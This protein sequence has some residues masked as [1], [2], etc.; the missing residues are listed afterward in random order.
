MHDCSLQCYR[1]VPYHKG[2][3]ARKWQLARNTEEAADS[4]NSSHNH[5]TVDTLLQRSAMVSLL[6][7]VD[8]H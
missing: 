5:L 2:R 1:T 8:S 6:K 7:F 4:H 3:M